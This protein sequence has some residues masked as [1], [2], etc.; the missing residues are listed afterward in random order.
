[1]IT[2][3]IVFAE[4]EAEQRHDDLDVGAG[5][6][7]ELLELLVGA[8]EA[9]VVQ[10]EL[11]GVLEQPPEQRVQGGLG[12][13]APADGDV[14]PAAGA[15]VGV[16][17]LGR[18]ERMHRGQPGLQRG[19][20]VATLGQEPGGVGPVAVEPGAGAAGALLDDLERDLRT[21][22]GLRREGPGRLLGEGAQGRVQLPVAHPPPLRGRGRPSS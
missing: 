18:P 16:E 6:R 1:M 21:G 13:L 11:G 15:Q 7:H 19:D 17:P 9:I 4:L 10:D 3:S 8:G 22:G 14:G 12:A 2:L 20:A 5:R